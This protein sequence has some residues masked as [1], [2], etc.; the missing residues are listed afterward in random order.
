MSAEIVP[1]FYRVSNDPWVVR[2]VARL[3][4]GLLGAVLALSLM[5]LMFIFSATA[6]GGQSYAYLS[7]QFT[8][9]LVGL[10]GATLIVFLPY[11]VLLTYYRWIYLISLAFLIGVL[12]FGV[13]LRGSKS[14]FDLQFIYFQP[15]ELT[16]LALTVA[17]AAYADFHLREL[18]EWRGLIVPF[19]LTGLHIGAGRSVFL[20]GPSGS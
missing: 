7:R 17:L 6:H 20:H 12:V 2:L 10:A 15:V 1:R 16:R 9:L 19:V 4:W 11:Q 3:D 13:K 5:G 14:W 8:A 18:R